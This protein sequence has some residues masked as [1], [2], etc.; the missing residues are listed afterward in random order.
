SSSDSSYAILLRASTEIT[1]TRSASAGASV[2]ATCSRRGRSAIGIGLLL[3]KRCD[4]AVLGPCQGRDGF[5]ALLGPRDER[6]RGATRRDLLVQPGQELGPADRL[7]PIGAAV[8]GGGQ[9]L[10]VLFGDQ[11]RGPAGAWP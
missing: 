10:L 4:E 8:I 2:T 1:R 5:P 11:D 9:R 7:G 6:D 3:S